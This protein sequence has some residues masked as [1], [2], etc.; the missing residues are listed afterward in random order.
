MRRSIDI[1][2]YVWKMIQN[3]DKLDDTT[4]KIIKPLSKMTESNKQQYFSDIKVMNYLLQGIPNDIY[5]SVDAYKT[6]KQMWE[7]IRRLMHD[8]EKNEQQRHSRLVDEFDKFVAVEGESLSSMYERLTTLVNVVER[9]NIR[10]LSISINTKFLNSLQPEWSKYVTMTRQNANFKETEFNNLFDTLSQYEPHVIASR[11]TKSARNRDPLALV[12]HS[13]V[14]SSHSHAS[15]L[16]SH[17]SQPYYVT[18]PSSVIDYKEDYQGEIHEDAQEDKLTTAMMLLARAI[19]QRYST[20][21]N[22][23]LRTSS[24]IRNQAVIQDGRVDIQSKNVGYVGNG[25]RN[26]GRSN[27][28]QIATAGNRM[29]QQIDAN[30]QIIQRVPRTESNPGKSNVQCYN[31]NAKGQYAHDCPQPKV[32]D[33]KYFREQMLL[34]LKDEARGNLNEEE[35]DFMLDHH[36]G[37]DSLEEL[38]AAVIMMARIQSAENNNDAEPKHD[39]KTISE[40]FKEREKSYLDELVDLNEK[41]SSH[42]R[43]VYKMG[44]S[45]QTIHMLGK[46][47]NKVYDSFLKAGLGYQNPERLKKAIKAQPKM[48]DGERLQS[49]K[50]IIDS[51]DSE[52]TLEDAEESRLKMKDKIIQLDYEKLNAL[53]ETFVP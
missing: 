19:T 21:T 12:A 15:P 39:A 10:P 7:R 20:P 30:D 26:T 23:R 1:G 48:Y 24:S 29:V 3:P 4:A 41:L 14:H 35:N 34:S 43:I 17:S 9:N 13:N 8:Y 40:A 50:L 22:N 2:L 53:Y 27:I 49:T 46:K 25:N 5:N 33:A 44:Q 32:R 31:Y 51:P 45:I 11:A 42:D 52:E 16:Y 28:N 6:A 36:Y 18:H 47:P 37:D 38:N